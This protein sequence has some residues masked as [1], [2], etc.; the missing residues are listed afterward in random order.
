MFINPF[1]LER[2]YT[3]HEFTAKY[4]LCSSDCEA[5][6]IGDLLSL[7]DGATDRFNNH[8]LGYTETKGSPSLRRDVAATYTSLSPEQIL[9]CAGAQEPIFLFSQAILSASDE[10]IVQFPCYQSVQSVP[11]SMGCKVL[12]WTV[13]YE[14]NKPV[15]DLDELAKLI[16]N[17]T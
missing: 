2:Y 6:T 1:K 5:M 4:A 13:K 14:G 11:E 3:I 8:W 12:K 15:F 9:V 17:R 10:V 16:S 7:E